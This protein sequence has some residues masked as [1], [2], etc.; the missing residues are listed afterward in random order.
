[1]NVSPNIF[2]KIMNKLEPE[3]RFDLEISGM[4][5]DLIFTRKG[6]HLPY[7]SDYIHL[8]DF[9]EPDRYN[10]ISDNIII[11]KIQFRDKIF[12]EKDKI[13][14][15]CAFINTCY[16]NGDRKVHC[17]DKGFS[18]NPNLTQIKYSVLPLT[19]EANNKLFHYLKKSIRCIVCKKDFQIE[20]NNGKILAKDCQ[21]IY[22][23]HPFA[24]KMGQ[25]IKD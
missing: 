4:H 8:V 7:F 10:N 2:G 23:L 5:K 13:V 12:F 20:I 3:P 25:T 21:V 9:Y 24:V 16:F 15:T 17:Y 18:S 19:D 11:K 22:N 6:E 14:F 1:M